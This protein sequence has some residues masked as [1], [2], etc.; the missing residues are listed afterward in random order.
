[1][2]TIE[3]TKKDKKAILQMINEEIE[4]AKDIMRYENRDIWEQEVIYLTRLKGR[5]KDE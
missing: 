3:I 5:I 2:E 4:S 1:M